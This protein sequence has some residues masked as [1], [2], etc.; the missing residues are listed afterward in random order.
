MQ[1]TGR[2][3]DVKVSVG[4]QS[5]RFLVFV[6]AMVMTRTQ[7]HQIVQIVF[8]IVFPVDDVMHFRPCRRAITTRI[9]TMLITSNYEPTEMDRNG[10]PGVCLLRAQPNPA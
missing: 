5:E 6:H 8:A 7:Q 10:H 3:H 4:V 2:A 9:P 1:M